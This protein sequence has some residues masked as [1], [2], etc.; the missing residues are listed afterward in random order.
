MVQDLDIVLVGSREVRPLAPRTAVYGI[1]AKHPARFCFANNRAPEVHCVDDTGSETIIR[2]RQPDVPIAQA[3]IDRY[4]ER[5]K[6]PRVI[7][8]AL[9]HTSYPPVAFIHVLADHGVLVVT[10]DLFSGTGTELQGRLFSPKG[11]LLGKVI[12]PPM[13]RPLYIENGRVLGIKFDADRVENLV[14]YRVAAKR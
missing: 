2:W 11:E 10:A 5:V 6:D 14:V 8:A 9:I 1:S 3:E 7:D 12:F 13:F 4:K